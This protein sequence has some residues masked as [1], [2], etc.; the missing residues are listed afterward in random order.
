MRF[1]DRWNE[2]AARGFPSAQA[3]G[4]ASNL[5]DFLKEFHGLRRFTAAEVS[6]VP[7]LT[8]VA[9]FLIEEGLP[10]E[11]APFLS[12]EREGR[13]LRPVVNIWPIAN[14]TSQRMARLERCYSLYS[15]GSGNPIC[16]DTT[17][18]GAL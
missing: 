10:E 8:D 13:L 16:I 1:S 5:D 12:L 3:T 2:E 11:A 18:D 14:S 15:D 4:V 9:R 17:Q 7:L 6:P